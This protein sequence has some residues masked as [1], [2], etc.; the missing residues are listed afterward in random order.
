MQAIAAG[1]YQDAPTPAL[2]IEV[3]AQLYGIEEDGRIAASPVAYKP[4]LPV[5]MNSLA[6]QSPGEKNRNNNRHTCHRH[7]GLLGKRFGHEVRRQGLRDLKRR[8]N[9]RSI[10]KPKTIAKAVQRTSLRH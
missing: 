1:M 10:G 5:N 4:Y 8:K 3:N 2:P 6:F 9:A 7:T